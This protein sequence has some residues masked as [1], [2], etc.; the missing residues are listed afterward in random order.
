MY[1]RIYTSMIVNALA[2]WK[3]AVKG[4]SST[5]KSQVMHKR[6]GSHEANTWLPGEQTSQRIFLGRRRRVEDV[7]QAN[8][9][10]F[11]AHYRPIGACS[12]TCVIPGTL[13]QC[14]PNQKRVGD[15]LAVNI[16]EPCS[17]SQALATF[18]DTVLGTVLLLGCRQASPGRRLSFKDIWKWFSESDSRVDVS[19]ELSLQDIW[20]RSNPQIGAP[21]ICG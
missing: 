19:K 8:H 2:A 5:G 4:H 14:W 21:Q 10:E 6:H 20:D 15:W 3:V 16:Y 13:V 17:P 18:S 9:A 12:C 1:I 7:F 11:I